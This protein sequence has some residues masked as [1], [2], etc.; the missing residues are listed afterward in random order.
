M[1]PKVDAFVRGATRWQEEMERLRAIAL[2]CGLSEELKWG[3]P[4]YTLNRGNVAIIQPF[5]E[6]CAFMFFKGELLNDPEGQLE[7]PGQNS[8]AAR[9]VMFSSVDQVA[10][11]ESHLRV[12]IA[13]AIEVE[14]GGWKV[15]GKKDREPIPDEL[16]EM[17]E[18]VSGLKEAF[19][20]LTPGRK[21][22]YILYF[23]SA[24]QSKTRMSRIEKCVPRI[25]DGRG[26]NG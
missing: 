1:N 14:R 21:R 22:A 10:R 25:L 15:Q 7:K 16:A 17:F 3:K 8:Q 5:K 20:A 18:R 9:R 24:K 6:G 23:A 13:E 19:E 4:C 2:D 11:M 26:L 12:F